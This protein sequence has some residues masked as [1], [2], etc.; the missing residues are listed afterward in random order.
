MSCEFPDKVKAIQDKIIEKIRD[1]KLR[2]KFLEEASTPTLAVLQE[3]TRIHETLQSMEN[4]EPDEQAN[5]VKH[6]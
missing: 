3:T 6:H 5:A 4:H 1:P 2:R